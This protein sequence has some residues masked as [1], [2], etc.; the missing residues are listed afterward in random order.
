MTDPYPVLF[1]GT[2]NSA[3]SIMAEALSL[4]LEML[5]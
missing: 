5:D 4:R 3:R 1:L 2:G